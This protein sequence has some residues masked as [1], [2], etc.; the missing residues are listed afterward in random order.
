MKAI[1]ATSSFLPA[2]LHLRISALYDGQT[3]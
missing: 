1:T 3:G 2:A